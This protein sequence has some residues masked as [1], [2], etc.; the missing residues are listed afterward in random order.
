MF[1]ILNN[2]IVDINECADDNGECDQICENTPG[3]FTCSCLE[4]YELN[5]YAVCVGEFHVVKPIQFINLPDRVFIHNVDVDPAYLKPINAT[6]CLLIPNKFMIASI[7]L[8]P[9]PLQT[10]V[11]LLVSL[12]GLV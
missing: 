7:I 8:L 3:S 6:C 5:H 11:I 2:F 1:E 9:I 4:G 10:S 12:V